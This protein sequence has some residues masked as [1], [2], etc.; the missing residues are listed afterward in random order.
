M[1]TEE[2]WII[3]TVSDEYRRPSTTYT[4]ERTDSKGVRL[5]FAIYERPD[6]DFQG[7]PSEK[8]HFDG[9][10]DIGDDEAV[11]SVRADTLEDAKRRLFDRLGA[12]IASLNTFVAAAREGQMPTNMS[13]LTELQRARACLLALERPTCPECL[14][15]HGNGRSG[16]AMTVKTIVTRDLAVETIGCAWRGPSGEEFRASFP[17]ESLEIAPSGAE[18][19]P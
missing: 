3:I 5:L 8:L 11:F 14:A 4:F 16:P 9:Y 6:W 10:L 2:G 15:Y 18:T 1:T 13:D 19:T 7:Q 12:F 17:P